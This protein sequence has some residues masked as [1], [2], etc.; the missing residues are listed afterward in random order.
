MIS[1]TFFFILLIVCLT[2]VG[3]GL[4][5]ALLAIIFM[6]TGRA[7]SYDRAAKKM[8][9]AGGDSDKEAKKAAKAQKKAEKQ[10]A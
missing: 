7:E 5:F 10:N 2:I 8:A 1:A 3:S 4:L 9:K 6:H